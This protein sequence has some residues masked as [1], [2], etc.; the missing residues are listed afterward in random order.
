M[1]MERSVPSFDPHYNAPEKRDAYLTDQTA[2]FAVNG[3]AIPD[4]NFDIGESYAGLLP[5]SSSPKETRE[6]YFW[7]F[8]SENALASDEIL[9]WLNG[10]PGCSSLEGLLQENGPFLWQ[11]GTFAPYAN[12]YTWVNLTN[13]VWVE[14]P[15]GTGFS[16]GTPNAT[17]EADVASQFM[18]F[19]KNFVD[20]FGLHGRKIYISGESYAGYY[21]P[22]IA[23]AMFNAEDKEYFNVESIMIYDPSTS[24]DVVQEEV[25][26]VAFVDFWAPVFSLNA[27]FTEHIHQ[28]DARCGYTAYLNEYLVYPPTGIL[29]TPPNK[30]NCDVWSDILNAALEI[31][32]CFDI[33]QILTTCPLLW[34]V[35]GFPGS[36][37]YSP[38]GASV[39]FNRSDV[40][41][42]INAP[43]TNW[44]ECTNTDV[45]V[46]NQDNSPP[47]GLS[48]LP[49]VIERT[50]KTIIGHGALDYILIANGTLLMIQNMTWNGKQGF[51][52]A[53]SAEFFVPYHI[54]YNEEQTLA[55]AGVFGTTHTERG[56]TFVEVS[57]SGHMI[58]QY[59]PSASYRTL[60]FLLG[61]I[62]SL[63]EK[64]D[65]TTQ[66]G[67]FTKRSAG[68]MDI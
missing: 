3:S 67:N 16:Q 21:V 4:V 29:P 7:F 37:P 9:I 38:P 56:L 52:K 55:G 19:F 11:Y 25:P 23:D 12:P 2:K 22:Y 64:G 58:P 27:S 60:E 62:S 47:S 10:G 63:T 15:V 35:L 45:F 57:L 33:Y 61:R 41:K 49:C 20:T 32:P 40:Q 30:E 53:P 39:Y 44:V 54:D 6:L 36:I 34:D 5:I 48:V 46:N 42:A 43:P 66:T 28:V 65:F 8:P 59:A 51:Q 14:Q 17:S 26:A 31:N 1:S 68:S 18:G 50:N 13:V 24:T